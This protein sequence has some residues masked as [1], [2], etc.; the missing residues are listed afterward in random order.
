MKKEV[1]IFTNDPWYEYSGWKK[2]TES[3]IQELLSSKNLVFKVVTYGNEKKLSD[4]TTYEIENVFPGDNRIRV[5]VGYLNTLLRDKKN[6]SIVYLPKVH[7]TVLP[8]IYFAHLFGLKV[9]TRISGAEVKG[10]GFKNYLKKFSLRFSNTCIVLN[11]DTLHQLKSK[12]INATYIP[13]AID[14]D[15]FYPIEGNS[16]GDYTLCTFGSVCRRKRIDVALKV[17]DGLKKN[18]IEFKLKII[19]PT[20]DF[21]EYEESYIRTIN[22]YIKDHE[23]KESVE[24]L[25][26]VSNPEKVLRTCDVLLF[27][28]ENEGMPNAL[29]EAMACGVVPVSNAIPGTVEIIEDKKNGFLVKNNNVESYIRITQNLYN[30]IE[31]RKKIRSSAISFIKENHDK[32]NVYKSYN[33][34][35][36]TVK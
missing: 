16:T 1:Y 23:L 17:A 22:D 27:P 9:V 33:R 19:G 35:F 36:E 34:I 12:K 29:L 21:G 15:R 24:F 25:G 2:Q 5:L 28:S 31:Y 20:S 3:M 26:L 18:E 32:S 13:N 11:K 30:D 6:I 4:R 10:N 7:L 8:L 14:L